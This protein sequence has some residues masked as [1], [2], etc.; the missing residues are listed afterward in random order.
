MLLIVEDA[1][2]IDPTTEEWI[3]QAVDRLR[4]ARVLMVITSRPEYVPSL[5][6]PLNATCLTM[7]RLSQRQS[8]AL[9]GSVSGGKPLPAEAT[10]EI[11]RKTDGV[12]LFIEELTKTVLA[13]EFVEDTPTGYRLRSPLQSLAIPS[14]LQDSLMARL[15]RLAPAKEVAQVAAAI[16]R[17]F[18][19]GLL[20]E[21]LQMQDAPLEHALD[22]LLR[23]ELVFR[24]GTS[25][26]RELCLQACVDSGHRLQQHGQEPA[27]RAA[28][29]DRAGT[30]AHRSRSS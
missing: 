17:D 10:K 7:N 24:R 28:R 15:D 13:S 19:H 23:A 25:A 8:A 11:I 5:G 12:P 16:G 18:G 1:H 29:A 30:G 2:W 26:G 6:S 4:D 14:T 27:S 9:I 21:V 3:G 22:E 20:A